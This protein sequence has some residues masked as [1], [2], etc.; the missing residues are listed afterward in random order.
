ML[1]EDNYSYKR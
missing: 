1:K